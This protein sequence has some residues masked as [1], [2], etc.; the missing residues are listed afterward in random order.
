LE[1]E[2]KETLTMSLHKTLSEDLPPAEEIR[3][4]N[5]AFLQTVKDADG[6][7]YFVQEIAGRYGDRAY[8][9]AEEVFREMGLNFDP[10]MLRTPGKVRKVGYACEGANIYD[11]DVRSY[12][13]QMAETMARFYN[14]VMRKLSP[15]VLIDAGFFHQ[16]IDHP[17]L[18]GAFNPNDQMVGF[19]DCAI[20]ERVGS[21][22]VLVFMPG[23]I[24]QIAARRLLEQAKTY[25]NKQKVNR[26]EALCGWIPYPFY[27]LEGNLKNA[28]R[29]CLPHIFAAL[30]RR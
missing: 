11:I 13:P 18:F 22:E 19:V 9:L 26:I 4:S 12:V 24:H 16:Q 25:F 14:N 6:Y 17:S 21:I 30:D 5:A 2:I 3:K 7:Y 29:E 15:A 10:A 23:T 28:I 27:K 1:I 8:D 20:Q